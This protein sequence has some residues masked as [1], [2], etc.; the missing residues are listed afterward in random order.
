[1]VRFRLAR[2]GKGSPYIPGWA[3]Q[4][5]VGLGEVRRGGDWK[6]K[7]RPGLVRD[8]KVRCGWA[9]QGKENENNRHNK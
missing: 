5:R 6:G 2:H 1:M 9:G 4:G 8:G 7:A 3:R